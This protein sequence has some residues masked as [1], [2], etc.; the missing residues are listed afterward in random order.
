MLT[1]TL[2]SAHGMSAVLSAVP[3]ADSG[4]VDSGLKPTVV[5]CG[6]HTTVLGLSLFAGLRCSVDVIVEL[7]RDVAL[8]D[9]ISSDCVSASVR[10]GMFSAS[11]SF[12]A[13][14]TAVRASV[15]E[16]S[17]SALLSPS[18]SDWISAQSLLTCVACHVLR[19]GRAAAALCAGAHSEVPGHDSQAALGDKMVLVLGTPA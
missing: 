3:A 17:S 18:S 15:W 10:D 7:A 16:L 5:L 11:P 2:A 6:C 1:F 14:A 8:K 4:T 19:A 12:A 9:W 13:P